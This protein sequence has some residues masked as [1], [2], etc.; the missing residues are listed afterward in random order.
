M[1]RPFVTIKRRVATRRSERT[2]DHVGPAVV[3]AALAATAVGAVVLAFAG[4]A[5]AHTF[6]WDG[7]AADPL[8]PGT[9]LRWE[10]TLSDCGDTSPFRTLKVTGHQGQTPI[11]G[12]Q[13]LTVTGRRQVRTGGRWRS[14]PSPSDSVTER[15]PNGTGTAHFTLRFY[16][17]FVDKRKRSRVR[18]TYAWMEATGEPGDADDQIWAKRT[19]FT[20]ACTIP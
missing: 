1:R 17:R 3:R 6:T 8:R 14:L 4:S 11:T 20:S 15:A 5:S 10:R 13:Y 9:T 2:D 16:L 19:R 7:T 18:L 12:E